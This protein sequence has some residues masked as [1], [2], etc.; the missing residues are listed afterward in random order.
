MKTQHIKNQLGEIEFRKKLVQQQIAG[1]KLFV[2]EYDR[3]GIIEILKLRMNKTYEQMSSLK[4]KNIKISP[5]VEIGAERCQRSLVMENDFE[6]VGFAVD[7]SRDMLESSNFY[8]KIFKKKKAPVKICA[9]AYSLPFNSNSMPFVFCYET[10]HHFPDPEPIIREI[11][12][13]L[14]PDGF[15]FFEEEPFKNQFNI[16]LY[17]VK[18]KI[19]SNGSLTKGKIFKLF[20]Y[21][22]GEKTCN[23]IDFGIIENDKI[24]L[25][26]W[27]SILKKFNK[28]DVAIKTIIGTYHLKKDI[29]INPAKQLARLLGG[30][31]SGLCKKGNGK[32]HF[33][34][35][36]PEL[37]MCP[38]CKEGNFDM[39]T[40]KAKDIDKIECSICHHIYPI[41]NQIIY[42]LKQEKL[43][44]LYPDVFNKLY[45]V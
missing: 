8:M 31:I 6:S 17:K 41:F 35:E 42:F 12:R 15:F 26:Y 44:L 40:L 24:P 21:F 33:S 7:I 25:H 18:N 43:K 29:S 23:E 39:T 32:N 16:G 38:N 36:D 11:Y 34:Y 1:E 19:Y 22:L 2:D 10:L 30:T 4:Q 3:D 9:D 27:M 5:Y 20:D 37:L 14:T 13:I 28:N 45:N